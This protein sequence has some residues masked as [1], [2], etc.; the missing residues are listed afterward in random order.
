MLF[1]PTGTFYSKVKFKTD[2]VE[3]VLLTILT[4]FGDY[5]I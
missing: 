3:K 2:G 1:T 5:S 4:L